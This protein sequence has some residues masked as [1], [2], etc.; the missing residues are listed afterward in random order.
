MRRLSHRARVSTIVLV[1]A[2]AS[3]GVPFSADQ[4]ASRRSAVLDPAKQKQIWDMEHAS[5]VIET[6]FG[7]RFVELLGRRAAEQLGALLRDDFKGTVPAGTESRRRNSGWVTELR[8][9]GETS[10]YRRVEPDMFVAELIGLLAGFDGIARSRLQVMFIDSSVE[11]EVSRYRTTVL[12]TA[13]GTTS[14]GAPIELVA[15]L[16]LEF[17][18]ADVEAFKQ[19]R[20]T[21]QQARILSEV[22]RTSKGWLMEE[23][24]E[25]VGLSAID[26]LDNWKVGRRR[27]RNHRHQLAVDDFDRDGF[28]D[29][30]VASKDGRPWLLRWSKAN[31]FED[32][33]AAMG[34]PT[35]EVKDESNIRA[36]VAW[37]D[38]DNDGYPD[39]LI[40]GGLYH[41]DKGRRLVDVSEASGL[42]FDRSPFGAAVA[43][44]DADGR[45]DL[46]IFYQRGFK[47]R[48]PGRRPWVGDPDAGAENQLWH[49]EGGGRFRNV[50]AS[51]GAGG[52]KHQTFAVA[53]FFLDDDR[54]PDLYLANDFASNVLLRNRGDGTFED[55]TRNSGTGDFA[56]SMGVAAGD[57]NNDGVSE[58]YVANMY[59]K[60]GR[61]IVA[62]VDEDDYPP[63]IY[64]LIRGSLAG[65]T[66]Y[67]R[68][69]GQDRFQELSHDL[70]INSVGWAYAPSMVDLDGDGWLDLY[71]STG[72]LSYDREKPDG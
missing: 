49:N 10:G 62:H 29:I 60:M 70:G 65:N 15:E 18:V 17:L 37:I 22:R 64:Q 38:Y 42:T 45:L 9:D 39:L 1:V 55:V 21:L 33:A 69:P 26:L 67:Q 24:T 52:G 3:G 40:G 36:L 27:T 12:L 6:Y 50:T 14:A 2:I 44:Y 53:T 4:A 5:F 46:Y 71:A 19:D 54:Y 11:G 23:V 35:Q 16:A 58:L 20:K 13:T 41:N 32:V 25:R 63:G 68:R 66:L 8:R 57:L 59:S 43:D 47:E 34:L 61:R 48:A 28:L 51:S 72:F 30:A 56:T 7:K 31:R